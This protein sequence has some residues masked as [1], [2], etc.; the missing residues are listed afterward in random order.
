MI[1]KLL[2]IVGIERVDDIPLLWEQLKAMEV[3]RLFD[4]HFP[5]HPNCNSP[6]SPGEVIACWSCFILSRGNHRLSQVEKWA[7]QHLH[8]LAAL[9]GKT[10]RPLDFSDDRLASL[11]ARLGDRR[12]WQGLRVEQQFAACCLVQYVVRRKLAEAEVESERQIR[13][14]YAGQATR[15]TARPTTELMLEAFDGVSMMIGKNEK[16]E[17][18]AWLT[19]LNELQKRIIELVGF[20]QE[21]YLR[22]V[23]HFQNL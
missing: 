17:T 2:E 16:G 8:L 22:P 1:E 14:L 11:P 4:K 18:L 15:A 6:L 12:A 10:V 7:A 5:Q 20:S 23:T 9:T 13:G 21:I 3:I 19:P